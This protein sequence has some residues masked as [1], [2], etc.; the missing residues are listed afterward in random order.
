MLETSDVYNKKDGK[1]YR[2]IKNFDGEI[3]PTR[4]ELTLTCTD[5]I[6]FREH[7]NVEEFEII[8]GCW[9][10]TEIGLFDDYINYWADIKMKSKGAMRTLAK[11]FLNNLYGKLASSKNSSFKYSYLKDDGSVGFYTILQENKKAAL[12]SC[13]FAC[14]PYH[15][16][17]HP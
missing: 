11:L 9:F 16:Y 13:V 15:K 6:L 8:S 7:Y 3:V 12:A 17:C 2:F 1:Y 14:E 4:V 10:N 5:Y